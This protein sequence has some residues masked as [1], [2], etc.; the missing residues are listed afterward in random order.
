M[1]LPEIGE[2]KRRVTF[3]CEETVPVDVD[4]IEH[5]HVSEKT[6]WGKVE[7]VGG[8]TYWNSVQVNESITHRIWV[9]FIAGSTRPQDLRRLTRISCDGVI[10][11]V[12]RV[13]DVDNQHRFTL[14]ECE[15]ECNESVH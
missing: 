14:C 9:R 3:I 15:E 8:A 2:L 11:L 6:V 13:T 12:R 5:R 7:V 10:F 4:D 1:K